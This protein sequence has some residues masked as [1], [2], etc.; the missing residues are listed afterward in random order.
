MHYCF[1]GATKSYADCCG[2][3]IDGN[4]LPATP[5]ELMRS[6]Y[7]AYAQA[8]IEYIVQTMLA[9][10]NNNFDSEAARVWAK[11]VK[12]IK[13][14]VIKAFI[15]QDKGFVEFIAYFKENGKACTIH[16]LSEFHK[17]NGRW[18]YVDGKQNV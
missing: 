10:A 12:W 5:E 4:K 16:E 15:K 11:R 3:F 9:P 13:L 2:Q 7:S 1:C 6:R 18:Y 17:Q 8:N 14:K